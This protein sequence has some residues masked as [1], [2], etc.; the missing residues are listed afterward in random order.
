MV[1]LT[2]LQVAAITDA[3]RPLQPADRRSLLAA[4]FEELIHRRDE[5][6]EGEL[7]RMLRELQR[8]HFQ[9]PTDFDCGKVPWR[10]E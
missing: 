4:L 7:H 9:P 6:G 5:L 3:V 1:L 10:A 2:D 8:K